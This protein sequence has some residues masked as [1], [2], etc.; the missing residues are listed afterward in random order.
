MKKYYGFRHAL[1]LDKI[2]LLESNN[3]LHTHAEC[4]RR[5]KFTDVFYSDE[6][7]YSVL[8]SLLGENWNEKYDW[9]S[10]ETLYTYNLAV[11]MLANHLG[12]DDVTS[13]FFNAQF[14]ALAK[15]FMRDIVFNLSR[16]YWELTE[17][18]IEAWLYSIINKSVPKAETGD[19][20]TITFSVARVYQPAGESDLNFYT[21][22]GL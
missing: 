22:E 19:N 13:R 1:H 18:D 12:I 9:Q 16:D 3:A 10:F 7:V 11:S 14:I 21:R 8:L 6:E 20:R 15:R 5:Q 4:R 17:E 2:K